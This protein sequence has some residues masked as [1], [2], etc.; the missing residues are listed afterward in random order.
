MNTPHPPLGTPSVCLLS[1]VLSIA[2]ATQPSWAMPCA[3]A[4]ALLALIAAGM[5]WRTSLSSIEDRNRLGTVE[6][7]LAKTQL[8]GDMLREHLLRAEEAAARAADTQPLHARQQDVEQVTS[9]AT[10][11]TNDL[12][13][14]IA[15]VIADMDSANTLAR[16]SGE[17]VTAGHDLMVQARAEIAHLGATLQRAADD[18]ATLNQQ[19]ARIGN[20]VGAITQI[21]D[22]TNLLALNAAIEAAR[23]GEAGRGFAVVADE[24]RKLAEQA[25]SASHQIGQIAQD[26]NVT[27]RDAANAVTATSQ[28]VESGLSVAT[29][30]HEAMAEIQAGAK[31]R[32][33]VVTNV[34]NNIRRQ[35][36]L[37][38]EILSVL[39]R[40]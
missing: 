7:Q 36:N 26:L 11:I 28:T 14:L 8:E 3:G 38:G 34:T 2:A 6:S 18:L 17:K 37:C 27:S 25:R 5:V 21:S 9:E 32:I 10:R 13:A 39:Q 15:Q 30:A 20:I 31:K 22:Q 23:A 1:A 33:E 24:V 16:G 4:A 29:Q 12:D 40:A 19:S 35:Q